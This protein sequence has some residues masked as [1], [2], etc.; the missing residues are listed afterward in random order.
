MKTLSNIFKIIAA[1]AAIAG[2]IYI[3]ATYG[4]RIVEKA[5][6]LLNRRTDLHF[7]DED[8]VDDVDFA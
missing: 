3:I 7:T 5:R 6:K 8:C 2:V 4:D 1:L